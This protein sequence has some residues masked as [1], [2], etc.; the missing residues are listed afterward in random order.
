MIYLSRVMRFGEFNAL[1]RFS[2][3][4]GGD[5][6]FLVIYTS[7]ISNVCVLLLLRLEPQV[8]EDMK[9]NQLANLLRVSYSTDFVRFFLPDLPLQ[10]F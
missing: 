7:C 3:A 1:F 6:V 5:C 9:V 2:D 4:E 10:D 8:R